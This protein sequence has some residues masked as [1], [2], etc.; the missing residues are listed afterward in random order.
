[1]TRRLGALVAL[2]A[3]V[4]LAVFWFLGWSPATTKLQK[5]HADAAVA[6]GQM[7]QLRG[8]VAALLAAERK[9]PLYTSQLNQLKQAV[10]DDP[11]Y[12][13]VIDELTKM[14][15]SSWVVLTSIAPSIANKATNA[16][17][18]TTSGPATLGLALAVGGTYPQMLSFLTALQQ[19]TRIFVVDSINLS[20]GAAAGA[21]LSAS[22]NGFVYYANAAAPPGSGGTS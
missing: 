17:A 20:G 1:M 12:P 13:V 8:Q 7:T 16:T 19:Q 9:V 18:T 22:I 14:A 15:A 10:P 6:T 21:K 4:F 3:F 11:S 2:I 5:A